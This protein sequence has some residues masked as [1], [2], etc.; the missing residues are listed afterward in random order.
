MNGRYAL[1]GVLR[2]PCVVRLDGLYNLL[3]LGDHTRLRSGDRPKRTRSGLI[4]L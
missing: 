3:M 4:I 2:E 1:R